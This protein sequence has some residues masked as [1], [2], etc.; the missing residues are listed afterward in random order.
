MNDLNKI[1]KFFEIV[2]HLTLCACHGRIDKF[3]AT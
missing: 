2:K 3:M 1:F